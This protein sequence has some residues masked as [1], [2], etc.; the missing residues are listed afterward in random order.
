MTLRI[1]KGIILAGGNGSRLFPAT[2]VMGKQLLPVYDKPLIYYPLSTLMMMGVRDILIIS[3]PRDLPLFEQLLGDGSRLGLQF[4]YREQPQPEGIAQAFLI[5]AEFIGRDP[6]ALILGDN[7]FYGKFDLL[8]ETQPF[9]AGA[10]IFGYGV[11]NPER[12]GVVEFDRD[13]RVVS[14]EEKPRR[15]KSNCVVT[16]LYVYDSEVVQIARSL[17]P[18]SRGELEITDVNNV[19][20]SQGKLRL[21]ELGR[22]IAWLDTGTHETMLEASNFIAT[23]ERRQGL[24]IACPEEIALR[25]GYISRSQAERLVAEMVDSSYRDYVAAVVKETSLGTS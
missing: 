20:L 11:R 10:V 9:I 8:R 5:G 25:M 14:I 19:Y 21:V 16:G 2:Q 22:G 18:S 24:K 7:I 13:H 17:K 6:I 15:P 23:I 4:R 3:T 1:K 12:Y